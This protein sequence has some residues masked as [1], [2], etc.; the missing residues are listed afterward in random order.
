MGVSRQRQYRRRRLHLGE[1]LGAAR[2]AQARRGPTAHVPVLVDVR[3]R[4]GL[5]ELKPAVRERKR[6]QR[7]AGQRRDDVDGAEPPRL[8]RDRGARRRDR[9]A[10]GCATN[11]T[12]SASTKRA[13]SV[14]ARPG[15]GPGPSAAP[16][17][18]QPVGLLGAVADE[19]RAEIFR[20]SPRRPAAGAVTTPSMIVLAS[21]VSGIAAGSTRSLCAS[22]S[23]A[24]ASASARDG[25]PAR[26]RA[27]VLTGSPSSSTANRAP[28]ADMRA[29]DK[30]ACAATDACCAAPTRSDRATSLPSRSSRISRMKKGLSAARQI[31][32]RPTPT[33]LL[34]SAA[35]DP[36]DG[37]APLRCRP[38]C[39]RSRRGS[40]P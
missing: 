21:R 30:T 9:A 6:D 24:T 27:G 13:P 16:A 31:G 39:R 18:H 32:R 33:S 35:R 12:P 29:R 14:V 38:A 11:I 34:F 4:P 17:L 1:A 3:G 36:R 15:A 20:R 25:A 10:R 8:G 2:R 5:V 26:R 7:R 40:A 22:H 23:A 19:I 37:A 28:V